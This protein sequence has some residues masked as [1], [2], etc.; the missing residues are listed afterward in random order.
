[1]AT[2]ITLE[3]KNFS[4][5]LDKLN[6]YFKETMAPNYD[7]LVCDEVNIRVIF[8][9]DFTE[10]ENIAVNSY[11]DAATE[12]TFEPTL[13]E[14]ATLALQQRMDWG[15]TVIRQFRIYSLG[16]TD[17]EG[18][19]MLGNLMD[20]KMSLE[21]GMLSAA[22]YLLQNKDADPILDAQFDETRTVRERFVQMIMTEGP[23][24]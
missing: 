11:W 7:G 22:A 3:W 23:T 4:V 15:Q 24:P 8:K 10:D 1:M 18:M 2:I 16:I 21:L 5:N 20:V 13:T 6:A 14:I 9:S 12:E 17:E 19:Q